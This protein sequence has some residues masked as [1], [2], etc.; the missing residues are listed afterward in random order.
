[1][2]KK[3]IKTL[4]CLCLLLGAKQAFAQAVNVSSWSGLDAE[5]RAG[6]TEVNVTNDITIGADMYTQ[7]SPGTNFTLN[8]NGYILDGDNVYRGFYTDMNTLNINNVTMQNFN[9]SAMGA[10]IRG[11]QDNLIINI[12]DNC[13]FINNSVVVG[14]GYAFGG[15]IY[16]SSDQGIN[17]G[18]NVLFSG[19]KA[20]AGSGSGNGG[21]IYGDN[22]TVGKNVTFIDNASLGA[23]G[24]SGGAINSWGF[25]TIDDGATFV[26]NSATGLGGAITFGT[27]DITINTGGSTTL[28]D[29]NTDSTG[30]NDIALSA[31]IYGGVA[32]ATNLYLTGDSGKVIFN[33]GISSSEDDYDAGTT[34]PNSPDVKII[35]LGANELVF[36]PDAINGNFTGDFTQ[37]AGITTFY[38]EVLG[39]NNTID[40]STLNLFQNTSDVNIT[41]LNLNDAYVNSVNG[42]VTAYKINSMEINGVNNFSID[43]DGAAETSDSYEITSGSGSG[44]IN[45]ASFNILTAP[46]AQKIELPVFTGDVSGYTFTASDTTVVT[47]IYKYSLTSEGNGVYEL[48]RNPANVVF[49]SDVFRGQVA[50]LSAYYNQAYIT[51]IIFGHIYFDDMLNTKGDRIWV[52]TYGTFDKQK[53]SQGITADNNAYGMIAG[54]DFNEMSL[55]GS[56][57]FF[58]TVYAS[59]N[60]ATQNYDDVSIYQNGAQAGV[61]GTLHNKN[62]K[63]SALLYGGGYANDMALTWFDDTVNNWFAGAAIKSAYDFHLSESFILQPAAKA[64]YNV[65]GK[66]NWESAYGNINMNSDGLNGFNLIPAV[67]FIYKQKNWNAYLTAQYVYNVNSELTGLAGSQTLPEIKAAESGYTEYALGATKQLSD[68]FTY[69]GQLSLKSG[70]INGVG[71]QAGF[72][73]KL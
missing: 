71:F 55:G 20:D 22:I 57:S 69:Y 23:A 25:L 37:T 73:I 3:I 64:S 67:S 52:K 70:A 45:I 33:G 7:S 29:G 14:S 66:Q 24:G 36:G 50:T 19:N 38:G 63:V 35:K 10:A 6:A 2:T 21:A 65:F 59:Y 30:A 27:G 56:W 41:N 17:I 54:I 51:D 8:G 5:M 60:V 43:I 47:P 16:T 18:D 12:G 39:G 40:D 58:P 42:T 48:W 15:V 68:V 44:A 4:F 26:N 53:M 72:S 62:F 46:T 13:S 32:S 49:N 11:Y 31:Y 61:L 1:M 34:L 9:N 28:F